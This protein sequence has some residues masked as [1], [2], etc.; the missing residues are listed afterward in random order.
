MMTLI[1]REVAWPVCLRSGYSLPNNRSPGEMALEGVMGQALDYLFIRAKDQ[2]FSGHAALPFVVNGHARGA[3]QRR[4]QF[5]VQ[6][7]TEFE[8]FGPVRANRLL[9]PEPAGRLAC[10]PGNQR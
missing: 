4:R 10:D 1:R 8:T 3:H 5:K 2:N 6:I 9:A 7:G